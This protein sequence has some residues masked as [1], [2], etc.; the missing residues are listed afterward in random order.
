MPSPPCNNV[1]QGGA[2]ITELFLNIVLV[3]RGS[4]NIET[5]FT[6]GDLLSY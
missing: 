2:Q 3:G 6:Q 4:C 1:V 5:H